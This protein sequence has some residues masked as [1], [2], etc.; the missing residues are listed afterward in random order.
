MSRGRRGRPGSRRWR[1]CRATRDRA[2]C[3]WTGGRRRRRSARRS[4]H[5]EFAVAAT[6]GRRKA[7]R[8]VPAERPGR[9]AEP[10]TSW[11]AEP[12]WRSSPGSAGTSGSESPGSPVGGQQAAASGGP[13]GHGRAQRSGQRPHPRQLPQRH[14]GLRR[15]A[16]RGHGRGGAGLWATV[17]IWR[18]HASVPGRSPPRR[19]RHTRAWSLAGAARTRAW[20]GSPPRPLR[21]AK[22]PL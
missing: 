20:G 21:C 6:V 2:V 9:A 10:R 17:S 13:G 1:R 4:S 16:H 12:R 15:L 11:C 7:T 18:G 22:L 14:G 3:R 8:F 19:G 5:P